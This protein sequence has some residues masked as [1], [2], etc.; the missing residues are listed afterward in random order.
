VHNE[1]VHFRPEP[2]VGSELVATLD[3]LREGSAAFGATV[4]EGVV[5]LA[6]CAP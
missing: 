6:G 3:R 5:T 2:L 1:R 4:E